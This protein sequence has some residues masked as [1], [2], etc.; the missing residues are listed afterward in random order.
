MK[1]HY[2]VALLH[3]AGYAGG[4]LIRILLSHP[5]I[6]LQAVT[7]RSFAG[8]PIWHA[9]PQLK[10]QTELVFSN[11]SAIL[12][13]QYDGLLVAGEHGQSAR[14]LADILDEGYE[15]VVVDLSA[16]FRLKT[17]ED[18]ERWY[19]FEHPHPE[20]LDQFTYGMPE[21]EGPYSPGTRLIAN[22]GCFA[23]GIGLSI[24]PLS[25]HL[26]QTT[27]AIT[28][29]TGASGS[30]ARP[31][32]TT[33]YPT[34]DGNV[35][36]YKVLSHQHLGEI[37]YAQR[38]THTLSFVPVSGPWTRGIWGTIQTTLP[39]DVSEKDINSWYQEA[40]ESSP[41][42]RLWPGLLP[43][44]RV[45]ARTPFADIGWIIQD[46]QLVVGFAIDNLLKGAASQAIQNL[47]ILLGLPETLGL[48]PATT[49]T[50]TE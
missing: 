37:N 6:S 7:S 33:H 2:S 49:S 16:D 41:L 19:A 14:L 45:A 44:L 48:I 23:T 13:N 22:P 3:G 24:W 46:K 29:M 17:T 5:E 9:H 27:L 47:N 28:A 38:H 35:R 25:Q 21:I 32:A 12:P 4:E 30:G 50:Y 18:Y 43:E 8:H 15:G 42:V 20:L 39:P 1:S 26:P 11:P 31:K 34:R 10:D 36:A 40:F